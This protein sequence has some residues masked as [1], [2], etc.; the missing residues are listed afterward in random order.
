VLFAERPAV[1]IRECAAAVR[2][3]V[4]FAEIGDGAVARRAR[5]S[6]GSDLVLVIS[7]RG[8][9]N[10]SRAMSNA[11]ATDRPGWC[12]RPEPHERTP[13]DA[14]GPLTPRFVVGATLS[15]L[16]I[17]LA[18]VFAKFVI[19]TDLAMVAVAIPGDA[20]LR[21]SGTVRTKWLSRPRA[22]PQTGLPPTRDIRRAEAIR[23]RGSSEWPREGAVVTSNG[24]PRRG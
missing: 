15:V 2:V 21:R 12:G 5:L 19:A 17:F 8:T 3:G 18:S 13:S 4:P 1:P 24:A 10:R 22:P 14:A 9:T 6:D 23:P 16:G 7:S 20:A 11:P